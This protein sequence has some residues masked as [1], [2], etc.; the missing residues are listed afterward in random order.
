[1]IEGHDHDESCDIWS[2]G[3]LM[4]ELLTG[5]PPFEESGQLLTY[6]RILNVDVR[7]PPGV[8]QD[9]RDLILR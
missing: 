7:F 6:T 3:V 8:A 4:Y 5:R 2:L 9:A 1:M